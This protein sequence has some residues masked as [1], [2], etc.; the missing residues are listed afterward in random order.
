MN[1][2][3]WD[4]HFAGQ[5]EIAAYINRV[6]EK[7]DLRKE[8]Q[9]NTRVQKA[10]F[11]S[12]QRI[13]TLTDQDGTQYTCRWFVSALGILTNP[14]LPNI[15]GVD[16]FKGEAHHTSR[17][18]TEPVKLEG[19]RV[20]VIGTGATG[21]QLIQEVSKTAGT[22]TVFQRTPMWACPMHNAKIDAEEMQQ[23]REWY[24]QM[25]KQC[26]EGYQ[27]F[28]H[29]PE[30]RK[31]TDVTDEERE[32]IWEELYAARGFGIWFSNF[33]DVPVDREANNKACAFLAKKIRQR[34]KDQDV[35]EK[36]IPKNHGFA[37][38]RVPLETNYFEVYNQPNV[39]LV[40]I[41]ETPIERI[42]ASGIHTSAEDY[43]FDVICY[44]TGFDAVTGSY[45]A[46]DT[47]GLDNKSLKDTWW[48]GP[49]TYLG[50]ATE[51]FPNL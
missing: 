35:A 31:T 51:R 9:F 18:P 17:W 4:E 50:F 46:I 38:R 24:P 21:I 16:S 41:N 19:K 40:D 11:D 47:K 33:A 12:S 2:W 28:L 6:V 34:V 10:R 48:G 39:T 20:A 23:L 49:K 44:A 32:R 25:M 37:T 43:E 45:D 14:T 8:M 15:P 36:L 29:N 26:A 27:G 5:P 42:S 1:E 3:H 13:W 30:S 7:H 22:L